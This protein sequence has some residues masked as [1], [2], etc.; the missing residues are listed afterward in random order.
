MSVFSYLLYNEILKYKT[1]LNKNVMSY[2]VSG[3]IELYNFAIK[4]I[5]IR[6]H[7]KEL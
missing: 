4:F 2:N 7:M 6:Y 1:I 5:F 3:L